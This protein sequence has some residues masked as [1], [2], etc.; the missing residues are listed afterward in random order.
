MAELDTNKWQVSQDAVDFVKAILTAAEAHPHAIFGF[1]EL[2]QA[3]MHPGGLPLTAGELG[4]SGLT[5][6][7]PHLEVGSL[8][9]LLPG[10]K[11]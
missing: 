8:V 1:I 7:L 10:G 2:P 11:D 3:G 6:A 4:A 9:H 5:S